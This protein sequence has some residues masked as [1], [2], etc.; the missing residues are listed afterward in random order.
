MHTFEPRNGGTLV[1]TEE[2]YAGLVARPPP[3]TLQKTLDTALEV[4]SEH[5]KAEAER[6]DRSE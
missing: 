2:S 4:S 5:L 6:R 3:S 1:K